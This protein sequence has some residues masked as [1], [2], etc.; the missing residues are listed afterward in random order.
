[1]DDNQNNVEEVVE[2]D[3][4]ETTVETTSTDS[5]QATVLLSLEEM[6]KS[7]ISSLDRLRVEVKK[8][9]EMFDDTFINNETYRENEKQA[10]EANKAKAT[11]RDNIMKQPGV[12]QMNARIKDMRTEIKER[13]GELSDYLHEYQRMTGANEI[14]DNDG[15]IRDIIAN[16]KLIKRSGKPQ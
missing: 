16:L 10:K 12:M 6:I 3:I 13:Q 5:N 11:T 2:A 9:K 15:V 8:Q 14:M 1:M 7:H 4:V